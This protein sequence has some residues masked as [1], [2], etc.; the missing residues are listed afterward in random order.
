MRT[1]VRT[2]NRFHIRRRHSFES[3][4]G[5]ASRLRPPTSPAAPDNRLGIALPAGLLRPN[6]WSVTDEATAFDV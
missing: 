4:R 3:F 5:S 6:G 2:I 1:R